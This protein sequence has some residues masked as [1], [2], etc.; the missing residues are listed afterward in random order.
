MR[1]LRLPAALLC[2]SLALVS[3][4]CSY[5]LGDPYGDYM[6]KADRWIDLRSALQ[7]KGLALNYV[8]G[9][10]VVKTVFGGT[11]YSYVFFTVS[12][13]DNTSGIRALTYDDLGLLGFEAS[14]RGGVFS[15]AVDKSGNIKIDDTSYNPS[16]L[17]PQLSGLPIGEWLIT[18][19]PATTNYLLYSDGMSQLHMD[20]YD[21][22]W[23]P[24]TTGTWQISST[25]AWNLVH[26]AVLSDGRVCLLFSLGQ[27]GQATVQLATFQNFSFFHSAFTAASTNLLASTDATLSAPIGVNTSNGSFNGSSGIPAW[28]TEK[29]IVALTNYNNNNNL[30]TFTRFP[31]G[32]G[33]AEDSYSLTSSQNN[34]FYFEPSGDYWYLFATGAGRLVR[35]R[36]WWK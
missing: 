21:G 23:T 35:M 5:L 33:A 12:Y 17:L 11:P 6:Q 29:G 26:V 4:G 19:N 15:A 28:I 16:A 13:T 25:G 24:G 8:N 20:S 31:L 10:A 27:G 3:L 30:E 14:P 2:T 32:P 18:D 9:L 34:L 36:A 1:M 22:L 7:T